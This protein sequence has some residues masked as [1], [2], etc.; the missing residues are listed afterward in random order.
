MSKTFQ[1]LN[2]LQIF[3]T[4]QK[5][6]GHVNK[7]RKCISVNA[8]ENKNDLE[9]L[10]QKL[11]E[12]ELKLSEL[13]DSNIEFQSQNKK[14][15][16]E[17]DILQKE[18]DDLKVKLEHKDEIIN[19]LKEKSVSLIPL[20][21]T[22]VPKLP[23]FNFR[24]EMQNAYDLDEFKKLINE[25]NINPSLR[26]VSENNKVLVFNEMQK[27]LSIASSSKNDV[28]KICATN[29]YLS[30][31]LEKILKKIPELK[32][33]FFCSNKRNEII[34]YKSKDEWVLLDDETLK[35]IAN[36]LYYKL[37]VAVTHTHKNIEDLYKDYCFSNNKIYKERYS[38]EL[39]LFLSAYNKNDCD[40]PKWRKAIASI[41]SKN[42]LK[43]DSDSE[44]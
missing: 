42:S 39:M 23:P 11:R 5:L 19:I 17:K 18:N 34:Y 44:E 38:N 9:E 20:N 29:K 35:Q 22:T 6:D 7:I 30:N 12:M 3:S 14:L 41:C 13:E 24:I 40:I 10:Q 8:S 4:K 16:N 36:S 25:P 33:P 2:C 32:R 31:T 28:S 1:C 43:N 26:Y 37:Y 15:Q 27:L 21:S